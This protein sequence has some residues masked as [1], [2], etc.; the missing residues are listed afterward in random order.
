MSKIQMEKQAVRETRMTRGVRRAQA[1]TTRAAGE[2]HG[3]AAEQQIA[4]IERTFTLRY[5]W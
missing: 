2:S 3:A 5:E 1:S 4:E